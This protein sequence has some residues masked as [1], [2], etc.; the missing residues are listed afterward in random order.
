VTASE[1]VG[2]AAAVEMLVRLNF[3]FSAA[4]G[5]ACCLAGAEVGGDLHLETWSF[6]GASAS[7]R[8]LRLQ[9]QVA[10]PAQPIPLDDGRV[11]LCRNGDGGHQL[12]L[13]TPAPEGSADE[14]RERVLAMLAC[15]AAR[16]LPAPVASSPG[17]GGSGGAW[18][19][20]IAFD[21]RGQTTIWRVS[22][23]QPWLERLVEL[24]GLLAG[25]VWLDQAGTVLG[26]EHVERPGEGPA[27]AVA[28]DLRDGSRTTLLD[29]SET[30]H[31]R[32]LL[33]SPHSGL[34]L[35]STDADGETRLGWAVANRHE[36]VRFPAALQHSGARA[37]ALSPDGRRVLLKT[38]E[39]V[40]SRLLAYDPDVDHLAEV[41]IPD[42]LVRGTASWTGDGIRFPFSAPDQPPAVVTLRDGEPA[43][44]EAGQPAG[45]G[46]VG[47]HVESLEGAAGPVEAIVY[48]GADWRAAE[49]VVLALHGGPLDAWRLEF[50]PLF[51]VLARAGIAI[52]APNQRGSSGYGAAHAL[53]LRGAWGGPDLEDVRRIARRIAAERHKLGAGEG[54]DLALLGFSYGA[55]LALLAA[56]CEPALWS[57]C[58]AVSPFLSGPR[59]HRDGA[60][61]VRG[62]L[63]R[64]GGCQELHDAIGPR[65]V[66]RLVGAMRARLLLIHGEDDRVIPVGHARDLRARLEELGRREGADFDYL[67]VPG[68]GHDLATAAP[69]LAERLLRFL[70]APAPAGARPCRIESREE[71]TTL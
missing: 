70:R 5:A 32:L 53:A 39:G 3:R 15:R 22:E 47:A 7:S 2:R 26:G 50:D 43:V 19:L 20:A 36:P 12:S 45:G 31:D 18:A 46:L 71:V 67:E 69:A 27:S 30:S 21:E 52:V 10:L 8:P 51:Q 66:P 48:G 49:R 55:W 62:L 17:V 4:G 60:E 11:L 14:A 44:V 58:V 68:G 54:G 6:A 29:V 40:R 35:V 1:T 28:V 42:G 24:P 64:L 63:D 9:R 56:S 38:D 57:C 65:D 59:L 33:A 23:R 25:G 16:L 41:P 13:V 34:L 61:P 37:L